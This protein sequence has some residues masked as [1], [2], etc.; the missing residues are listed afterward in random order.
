MTFLDWSIL[1]TYLLGMIGLSVYLGRGQSS[2]DDYYVG[3]RSL[4]WWAIGISTMATQSSAISFISKP[5]FVALKPG[6]GMTWLQF[7]LAVPLAMIVIIAV[8]VPFFRKL[9][10]VSVYE[11]LELRFDKSIRYLI[12][13]VFLFSRGLAAGAVIYATAIV[14]SVCLEVELWITILI[15]GT[16]TVIYDTIGG[17]A[18]VVYSDVIQLVLLLG[19]IA[20]C[21][22]IAIAEV[23]SIDG[24][25]SAL[26]SERWNALDFSSGF[27]DGSKAPFWG[28]FIGGFF[29]YI[30]YY[31]TDQSQV[32]R[33]LSS[34]SAEGTRKSLLFN[35]LVR[36]PL[37]L[38]YMFLG[39]AVYAVY[40][41][42]PDLQA[43]VPLDKPDY[44]I[45]QYI[46][47]HLPEGIRALLFAAILAAA[48]SSID[49]TLNSLS[50]ATMRDFIDRDNT[51]GDR[52]LYVSKITTVAWG[53]FITAFAFFVPFFKDTL[54]EV[55]NKIGSA[56]YG[57]I[58]AAFLIGILSK[59]T[60]SKG[61]FAGI[62]S[63]VAINIVLWLFFGEVYWMWWNFIGCAVAFAVTMLMTL[64][65]PMD[66]DADSRY[67][68][69][70][71]DVVTAEKERVVQYS[72]L[73]GYFVFMM[74]CLW[75]LG[76]F[77]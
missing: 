27:G 19:G 10:L 47:L 42:A 39:V 68:L 61:I 23:G 3:G 17:M 11:Y 64:I 26:P 32:Q 31:G 41:Q 30:S 58:V 15:I 59:R 60:S 62:I 24:V 71:S 13:G 48:M 54:I 28:V 49:S 56:F 22:G 55:V 9:E 25:L 21:M 38:A 18:A 4:P 77:V 1:G 63:G 12:S 50:A 36:F 65:S 34:E 29:L 6:G 45:P 76:T 74:V 72:V 14:L 33:E 44:L 51:L 37:T 20:L 73:T 5:A 43:A 53:I 75:W 57:P 40:I 16:V 2:A 7:E 52:T 70:W 66:Q 46:L 67:T 8:L 69:S 35:G